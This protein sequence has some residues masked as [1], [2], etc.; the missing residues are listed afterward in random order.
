MKSS[1]IKLIPAIS[2]FLLGLIFTILGALF[3][4]QHWQFASE[5]LTIGNLIE[6]VG[7]IIAIITLLRIYK[8]KA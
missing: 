2:I 1:K 6:V 8:S 7:I 4:I 3:K 5:L